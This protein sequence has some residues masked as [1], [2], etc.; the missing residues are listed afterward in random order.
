MPLD[1]PAT[2][3]RWSVEAYLGFSFFFAVWADPSVIPVGTLIACSDLA[4]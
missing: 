2:P 4:D 1:P 3:A